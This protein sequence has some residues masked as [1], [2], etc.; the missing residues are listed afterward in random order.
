VLILLIFLLYLI[1]KL[2]VV[3]CKKTTTEESF[4]LPKKFVR[5]NRYKCL[6]LKNEICH[7]NKFEV[8]LWRI[9]KWR[10]FNRLCNWKNSLT[11]LILLLRIYRLHHQ[12]K[13][14][15]LC[16]IC[17][18][19]FIIFKKAKHIIYK[20]IKQYVYANDSNEFAKIVYSY[21]GLCISIHK[22]CNEF[23]K[24][25]IIFILN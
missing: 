19:K 13:L 7:H 3:Y 1:I 22:K 24:K 2:L 8:F 20:Q 10:T 23:K 21:N 9:R 11:L 17:S 12:Q 6:E 16:L 15:K 18:A 14:E 5:W 4:L 25:K